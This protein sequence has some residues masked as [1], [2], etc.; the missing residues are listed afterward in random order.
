M[1][2]SSFG[3]NRDDREQ[4]LR[5]LATSVILYESVTTTETKARVI[6]PIVE[7]LIHIAK[8]D[9]PL[10]ARRRLMSYLTDENAV[11]KVLDELTTRYSDKTSGFTRRFRLAPRLGDGA[12]QAIIQLTN[13]ILFAD[14]KPADAKTPAKA[15]AKVAKTEAPAETAEA[16]E[17]NDAAQA[18]PTGE[19]NE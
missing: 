14:N 8:T 12:P 4:L 13:S 1:K 5:N 16:T 19:S 17:I 6:Q 3:R 9:T 2:R 7:H 18:A 15:G 10:M 11:N